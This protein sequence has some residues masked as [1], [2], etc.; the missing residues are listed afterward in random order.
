MTIHLNEEPVRRPDMVDTAR[1]PIPP[2]AKPEMNA[3]GWLMFAVMAIVLL[4]LLPVL[5]VVWI[6]DSIFGRVPKP[7]SEEQ[8]EFGYQ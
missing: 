6:L 1:L 7:E 3:I 5:L 4:P 8:R 2:R